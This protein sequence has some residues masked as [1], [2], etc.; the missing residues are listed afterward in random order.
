MAELDSILENYAASGADTKDKVLG[1]SFVVVNEKETLYEGSAGRVGLDLRA[2]PY[3]PDT[4][5]YVASL[6]KLLTA[7]CLLQLVERG[8][9]SLDE[10]L[11]A[12]LPFL[13][14]VQILRG[15]DEDDQP[16][17]EDNHRPITLWHLLS[18]TSGLA[19]D[20]LSEPLMKW[21]QS[22]GRHRTN[23]T[24]TEEGF[25][26]PL[27]FEPGAQWLYGT[28]MDWAGQ[29]LEKVTGQTLQEYATANVFQVLGMHDS[30][31]R[32]G[33][34]A[35]ER[36]ARSASFAF[37]SKDGTLGAGPS[38]LADEHPL[39]SG[40]SGLFTTARDYAKL[41]QGLLQGKLL[42][43][44]A[45]EMLFRAQLGPELQKD[46]MEKVA[47]MP[48]GLAPEY[49]VDMP[50]NFAFGGMLNLEDIPGKRKAGSMMWSGAANSHWWIDPST[51]IA[52]VMV[53]TLFPYS[54]YVA[55]ELYLKLETA[56]SLRIG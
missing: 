36:Q 2:A 5:T 31:F 50:A 16:I 55:N 9:L 54:D 53:V 20:T 39:E 43:A 23:T 1:V 3:T 24:W 47:S 29:V 41:L 26:T 11:G 7:T 25:S 10:D 51:G 45:T 46:L 34:S 12:R 52:A 15:F 42:G 14:D 37:R 30:T 27:L 8:Q 35:G 6:T 4:F 22:V 21:R 48:E 38:P 40:G 18:H 17:L 32:P 28:G 19:Y 13:S 33:Q 56:S 49:P 44:E